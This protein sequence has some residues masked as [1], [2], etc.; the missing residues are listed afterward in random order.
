MKKITFDEFVRLN[1]GFDLPE[2]KIVDGEYPVVASTNIKAYHNAYKVK[3]PVVVTGRS[4]SLGKVQYIDSKCWPLNTSLYSKDFRGNN[5]KYIYYFLQTMHLEQYNAGAG[6]P[7]LNQNHLKRLKIVV[8]DI[9]EQK[10]VSDILSAYDNLIENNNKRVKLLEQMVENLYKEW[11]VRFRFPGYENVEFEGK[12]P[13]FWKKLRLDQ[14]GI[15]LE[16]GARPK[17]GINSSI[18]DGVPSLGAESVKGLAEFDYSDVKLIPEEFYRKLKR[19]KN[20][21]NHILIYKDGAYIGKVTL[22]KYGFPFERFAINEHVFFL[23]S[24][25]AEYQ[26]YLYFT[27]KQTSY[28]TLMQNLNRNS[29]QPGLSQL[30]INRIKIIEP[31]QVT[32]FSFNNFVEPILKEVFQL[33][34]KN[35]SL[36]K[37][38]DML[39]PRLMSGKLEV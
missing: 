35:H 2:S 34:K 28:F 27:L 26:N 15:Q 19:G 32:L 31:D 16:S 18:D 24:I 36:I 21:G 25:R 10:K 8:H 4:G 22:F 9:D 14:F 13:K 33:A 12:I 3:P 23:N 5:P 39:L 20:R 29:A 7:T 11:F 1:R 17:G 6:V 38:R 37:R 30:D